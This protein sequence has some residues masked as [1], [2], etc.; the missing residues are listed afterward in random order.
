[1][2]YL[3][4]I[5]LVLWAAA[6]AFGADRFPDDDRGVVPNQVRGTPGGIFMW[7]DGFMGGK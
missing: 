3:G 7:R 1:M 6:H 5:L 2:K 4:G